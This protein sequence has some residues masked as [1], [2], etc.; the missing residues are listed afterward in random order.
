MMPAQ[1]HPTKAGVFD[2]YVMSLS[3]APDFCQGKAPDDECGQHRGFVLHGLWPENF[4][5]TFPENCPT[6]LTASPSLIPEMPAAIVPHEWQT[7]GACDVAGGTPAMFFRKAAADFHHIKIPAQLQQPAATVSLKPADV[8]T[9]FAT[10]NGAGSAATSFTTACAGKEVDVRICLDK[11][12][13]L[14]R[15][16]IKSDCAANTPLKFLPT[17]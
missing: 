17:N 3:W 15:C 7:H 5:G 11:N 10:A 13:L 16:R 9:A 14:T 1:K 2:Y 6:K 8:A 4:D 12:G